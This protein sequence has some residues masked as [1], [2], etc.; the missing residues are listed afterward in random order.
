VRRP[1][2]KRGK[3]GSIKKILVAKRGTIITQKFRRAGIEIHKEVIYKK[4]VEIKQGLK[5]LRQVT[6]ASYGCTGWI[7]QYSGHPDITDPSSPP[8]TMIIKTPPKCPPQLQV[9]EWIFEKVKPGMTK[10]D[11]VKELQICPE[12]LDAHPSMSKF[13]LSRRSTDSS[14]H[15]SS[16]SEELVSKGLNTL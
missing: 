14:D 16:S 1:A 6:R 2:R 12:I 9:A 7:G 15:D 3:N 11:W 5:R 10:E 4:R 8:P 13:K